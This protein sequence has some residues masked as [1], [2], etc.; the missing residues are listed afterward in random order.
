MPN[1]EKGDRFFYL[2]LLIKQLL[3]FKFAQIYRF[4]DSLKCLFHNYYTKTV[5]TVTAGSPATVKTLATAGMLATAH[6][7]ATAGM[8]TTW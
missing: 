4:T 7:P 5:T 2:I 1:N 3:F 8:P 6:T